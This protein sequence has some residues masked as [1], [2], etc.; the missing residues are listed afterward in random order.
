MKLAPPRMKLTPKQTASPRHAT[1]QHG[2][3][4]KLAPAAPVHR[5]SLP[6][7]Q[8]RLNR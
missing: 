7:M 4:K 5:L 8:L 1:Q 2:V 3:Q 6:A